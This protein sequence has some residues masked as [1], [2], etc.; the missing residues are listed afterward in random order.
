MAKVKRQTVDL[1]EYPDLVVSRIGRDEVANPA[2]Q[3]TDLR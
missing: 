2:V 3:E 1:S